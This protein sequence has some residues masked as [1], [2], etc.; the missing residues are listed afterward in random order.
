MKFFRYLCLSVLFLV[1]INNV[2]ISCHE[3]TEAPKSD[4]NNSF[5]NIFPQGVDRKKRDREM[6]E[7]TKPKMTNNAT[8]YPQE[9]AEDA[10]EKRTVHDEKFE[11]EATNI[12]EPTKRTS[13]EEN[14]DKNQDD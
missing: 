6:K 2:V 3:S 8:S 4:K 11:K 5:R 9:K 12:N 10:C 1:A 13:F 14:A 7:S